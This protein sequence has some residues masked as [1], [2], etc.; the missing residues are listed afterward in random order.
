[1]LYRSLAESLA[2]GGVRERK[3]RCVFEWLW[4]RSTVLGFGE[5]IE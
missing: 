4:F 5:D 3:C 1:M 2:A